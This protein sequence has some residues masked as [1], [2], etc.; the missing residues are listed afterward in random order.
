MI[1]VAPGMRQANLIIVADPAD[2]TY[3]TL[4][5]AEASGDAW[6]NG[7]IIRLTGGASDIDFLYFTTLLQTEWSGLIHR[8]PYDDGVEMSAPIVKVYEAAADPDSWTGWTDTSTG[9][10]GVDYD[11]DKPAAEGR[12]F[13]QSGTGQ[14]ELAHSN[15][16]SAYTEIFSA[17]DDISAVNGLAIGVAFS[18]IGQA[19]DDGVNAHQWIC[20]TQEDATPSNWQWLDSAAGKTDTGLP[21]ATKTRMWMYMKA[22]KVVMWNNE[23]VSPVINSTLIRSNTAF[24]FPRYKANTATVNNEI[25]LKAQIHGRFT[26]A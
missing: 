2:W 13:N 4:A 10:K 18:L 8:F 16:T 24:T 14:F 9:T 5:V 17:F 15:I 21:I 11:F 25:T 6:L 20:R 12:M 19:Y 23:D 7:D 26:G 22:G 3:T 1:M